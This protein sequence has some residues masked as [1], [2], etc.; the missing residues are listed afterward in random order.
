MTCTSFSQ[1]FLHLATLEKSVVWSLSALQARCKICR[2][3][4][5]GE[6]MLLCDECNRGFHLYCLKPPL[7]EKTQGDWYCTNCQY[8]MKPPSPVKKK[9]VYYEDDDDDSNDIDYDY[10]ITD[11]NTDK[12]YQ[13]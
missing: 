8:K 11:E 2:R 7:K 6:N 13:R 1:L 5:D 9:P 4:G 3:K 10:S 12:Q